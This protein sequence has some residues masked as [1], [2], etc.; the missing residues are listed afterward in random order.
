MQRLVR[1]GTPVTN[2]PAIPFFENVFPGYSGDGFTATQNIYQ[3]YWAQNP[4][5][6]TTALQGID[7]GVSGCS[8]CSRF[9]PNALYSAQYSALT[10]FRSIG[11]GNYHGFQ[12]TMRKRYSNGLQFDFNYTFSK[13]IDLG[14]TTEAQGQGYDPVLNSWNPGQMRGVS[15]YDV[16]HMISAFFV[17]ELPFGRGHAFGGNINRVANAFVGGW[18][19][20]G[21]WSLTSGLPLSVDNGGFWP[22]NW[23]QEGFTTQTGPVVQGTTKNS[24]TGPNMFPDPAAAFSA[25]DYT[26]PGQSGSRNV[27][28]GDRLF[29]LDLALA[30]RFVMP[31][32]ERHSIQIRAEAFNVSNTPSFT[33]PNLSL[34]SFYGFGGYTATANSP[35]IF[36]FGA[37]YE[38]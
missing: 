11:S 34:G 31:W 37:R 17:A 2:V 20:S 1:A 35:R 30:K 28:R 8:P 36:Q 19:V 3:N 25:F 12:L 16:R 5:S 27:L 6:D 23:N 22:T 26:Y 14:S 29:N 24:P 21:I 38:F 15:D 33:S 32:S 13:S 10:A 4:Q 7:S 18:Q 9:G